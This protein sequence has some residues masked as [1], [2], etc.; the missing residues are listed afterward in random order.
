MKIWEVVF[1]CAYQ[2]Y[3]N[4]FPL[5]RPLGLYLC[6]FFHGRFKIRLGDE[7]KT[8]NFDPLGKRKKWKKQQNTQ[9]EYLRMDTL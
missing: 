5:N 8:N 3:D 7:K 9:R 2:N 1:V 6:F 4:T